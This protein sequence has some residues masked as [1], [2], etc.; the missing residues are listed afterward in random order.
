MAEGE[1]IDVEKQSQ[2]D[3]VVRETDVRWQGNW[4]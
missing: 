4:I 2:V 1:E 3:V